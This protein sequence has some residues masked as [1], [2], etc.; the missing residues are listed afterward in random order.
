MSTLYIRYPNNQGVTSINTLTGAVTLAAG[1][2]ISITPA[3]NTLTIASTSGG[4]VTL[5]AVGSSPNNNGASLSGQALTLQP[6]DGTHPGLLTSGTQSI[7]GA[8]TFTGSISA[9]NLSGTNTGDVTLAAVG[10]VPNANGASLSGQVLNLQP[11]DGSNPGALTA[12]AQTIGGA[13]TLSALTTFGTGA[14]FPTTGGTPTTL[15]YYEE[16][17]FTANFNADAGSGGSGTS[18]TAK[19]TRTGKMVMIQFPSM[20]GMTTGAGAA[21]DFAT[22]SGT[23]P[24]RLRPVAN[25]YGMYLT[26]VSGS[27]TNTGVW[28]ILTNG[29]ILLYREA[30]LST[31]WP[32]S[33]ANNGAF[34]F[35]ACYTIQ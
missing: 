16:G 14:Q 7:G 3:G 15:D 21:A 8:K 17:T 31:N 11:A 24:S 5:T 6:A 27:T 34:S 35:A 32:T 12:G 25:Q 29:T 28:N 19:F 20:V 22:A 13:K 2:G 18:F 33:N 10:A 9:T 4:D 30:T 1:T 26:S 23:V